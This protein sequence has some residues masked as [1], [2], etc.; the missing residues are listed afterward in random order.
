M[1]SLHREQ[2]L[3][4]LS[5]ARGFSW[6]HSFTD[7]GRFQPCAILFRF[8]AAREGRLAEVCNFDQIRGS[9]LR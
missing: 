2:T 7:E 3:S 6:R 9:L 4:D 1:I 8:A 5:L